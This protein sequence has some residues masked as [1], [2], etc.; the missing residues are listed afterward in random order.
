MILSSIKAGLAQ[1]WANKRMVLIFFLANFIFGLLML[2]PFRAALDDFVGRSMMGT[3]LAGRFDIDFLF[4]FLKNN[5]SIASIYQSL[6]LFVPAIYWL[7]ALFLSG[8]AL[9]I[10]ASPEKYSATEFWGSAAKRFGRFFR[11]GVMSLILLAILFGLQF[12]LVAGIQ[13]LIFGSDPYQY[14]TY[15]GGWIKFTLRIISILLFGLVLDYARIHAVLTDERKMRLSFWHG[16]KLSFGNIISTFGL[17]FLLFVSG[18]AVLAIYNPLANSLAAPNAFVVLTLFMV[19]QLYIFFRMMLR[20]TL[21]SSQMHLYKRLSMQAAIPTAEP[22]Q[23]D[24]GFE[25]AAA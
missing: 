11:L 19:Q 9:A 7:L 3:E 12:G 14:V 4:E 20:L 18:A 23:K 17:T 6:F 8:G 22:A 10:F 16:I 1:M 15:W 25:G 5:Q 21:Y 2:L 24:L 13:R